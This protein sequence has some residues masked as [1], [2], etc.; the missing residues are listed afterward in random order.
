M[1]EIIT[2]K[3]AKCKGVIEIDV[4]D[5]DSVIYFNKLYYH[6]DCFV[7]MAQQKAASK[8]G[9]PQMWQD[10]LNNIWSLEA[11]TKRM[12]ESYAAKDELNEWL[13][14]N[15]DVS[16]VPSYFWQLVVDLESGKYKNK[17]CKPINITT[18]YSMWRWGQ[19][20]LN[21][22]ALKNKENKRGPQTDNDR[23]RYDL[24]I[25]LSHL[26]DFKRYQNKVK[27]ERVEAQA[28][29]QK[30]NKNIDYKVINKIKEINTKRQEDDISDI[31]DEIFG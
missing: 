3:C 9:K 20:R 31:L 14:R 15:Y 13:L 5:I 22:I 7:D 11:E 25:L 26:E 12:L 8:R 19:K 29:A 27:A 17:R 18:L 21:Q 24:S 10:A 6:E 1:R 23:I 16:M 28:S 4:D 2:R 30:E